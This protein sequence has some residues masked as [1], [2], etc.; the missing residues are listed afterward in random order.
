MTWPEAG[1]YWLEANLRDDRATLPQANARR[2]GY[3]ATL[4]V[5][6]Q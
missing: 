3:V 5:L 6:P 1:M 4:E 2:L